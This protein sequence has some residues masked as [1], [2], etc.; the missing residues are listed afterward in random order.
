LAIVG[1]LEDRM[2]MVVD[3]PDELFRIV[4]TDVDRVRPL[5]H[6]VPLGPLFSDLAIGVYHDQTMLPSGV[7]TE[8]AF[9]EPE[10]V[11]S[12]LAAGAC[13]RWAGRS[14]ISKRQALDW[15]QEVGPGLGNGPAL[16]GGKVRQLAP[17][18]DEDPVG[19]FGEDSLRRSPC[20]FLMLRQLGQGLWPARDGFVG[21]KSVLATFLSRNRRKSSRYRLGH[22]C[23]RY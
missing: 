11:L 19:A 14:G 10:P 13:C 18:K 21:A 2:R 23:C 7:D 17:L 5:Q 6:L 8:P 1:E 16:R 9:V 12:Q 22:G 3:H 15:E 4:R 20:P